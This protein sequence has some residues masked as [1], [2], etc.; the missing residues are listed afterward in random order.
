MPLTKLYLG[1]NYDV[2]YE[3]FLPR[4][5]LVSDIPAGDGNIEKLFLRYTVIF[6]RHVNSSKNI[7]NSRVDSSTRDNWNIGECQQQNARTHG[8]TSIRRPRSCS[9]IPRSCSTEGISAAASQ[10]TL[11]PLLVQRCNGTT[12]RLGYLEVH[13]VAHAKIPHR[14]VSL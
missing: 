1:G 5:S 12:A 7:S 3:L 11:P 4:E 6:F 8:N 10:P 14:A 9:T 2:I 13:W